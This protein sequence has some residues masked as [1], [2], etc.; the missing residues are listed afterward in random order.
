M[1]FTETAVQEWAE[2]YAKAEKEPINTEYQSQLAGLLWNSLKVDVDPEAKKI[3]DDL[4]DNW[5]A[6][7][8]NRI[9]KA[10]YLTYTAT[11]SFLLMVSY[12]IMNWGDLSM[13]AAYLQ[14]IS[15][16]DKV[17]KFQAT[18]FLR[19]FPNHEIPTAAEKERLWNLQKIDIEERDKMNLMVDN[20]LDYGYCYNSLNGKEN[21]DK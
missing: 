2:A 6:R 16:R 4:M 8:R 9:E 1:K 7:L 20:I 13:I 12:T 3:L 19:I 17:T 18:D 10:P 5:G 11:P 21:G 15:D 14:Y